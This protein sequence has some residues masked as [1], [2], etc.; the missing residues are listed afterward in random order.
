M[1]PVKTLTELRE[2]NRAHQSEGT[3]KYGQT[4]LDISDE[5][6][7]AADR[8]RYERD[9]ARDVRLAGAN[10]IDAALKQYEALGATLVEVTLPKTE[11]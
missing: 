3:L 7:V 1:A 10:G 8:D 2:W 4:L 11:L 6:D 5:M 9:R